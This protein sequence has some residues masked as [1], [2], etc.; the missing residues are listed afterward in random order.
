MVVEEYVYDMGYQIVRR[1]Q[2]VG[3]KRGAIARMVKDN[4][5]YCNYEIYLGIFAR[6]TK[7]L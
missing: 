3:E 6:T 2:I 5:C 1:P 4:G 7:V